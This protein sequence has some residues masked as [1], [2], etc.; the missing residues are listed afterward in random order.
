MKF[1]ISTDGGTTWKQK[2]SVP[3]LNVDLS[4]KYRID[5]MQYYYRRGQRVYFRNRAGQK[6]S[7]DTPE[8]KELKRGEWYQWKMTL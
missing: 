1:D 3:F 4:D 8:Y 6:M 7:F 2:T 5:R